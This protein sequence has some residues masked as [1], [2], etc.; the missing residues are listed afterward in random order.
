MLVDGAGRIWSMRPDAMMI[1]EATRQREAISESV[2]VVG[3]ERLEGSD[4]A[5]VRG[6]VAIVPVRG[7]LLRQQN[8]WFWSYE[9]ILRD[10]ALAQADRGV[11]AVV[12][13]ID[14]PGGMAAGCGDA[15]RELRNSGPKPIGAFVGGL[16]AS[17][18]FYLASAADRITV[19]SCATV[20]SLGTVIEFVDIEPMIERLGAR[21]I[22]VVAQQ[23]PNKRLDPESPEGHA[24]MQDLVDA[25]AA[26]FV[27]DV[28]EFRGRSE[29]EVL[30]R[31]GQGLVFDG[32]EALRRGMV[33]D[34]GTLSDLVAE[35]AGRDPI[36]SA[37]PAAAQPSEEAQMEWVDI[38]AAGLREQR[39]DLVEEISAAAIAEAN[40][41]RESEVERAVQTERARIAAIDEIAVAGHEDVVAAAKADGRSAADLALDIVK[42]EK[43]AGHSH[44]ASLREA[45]SSAAVKPAPKAP[46]GSVA[47]VTREEEWDADANLRAEFGDDKGAFLAWCKNSD[48]GRARILT[49]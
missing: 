7:L 32:N 13:D 19:G 2:D 49:R 18:A 43:A 12:L 17:A 48:A 31:F 5:H 10:V 47:A 41:G 11:E 42:A 36:T 27:A 40:S 25:G 34:R 8:F 21:M 30:S 23:S 45:D 22:R 39:A 3:A 35:M 26:E 6:G 14:S 24:E 16:C 46:T 20:G 28:G 29:A 9:E 15:A 33:D 37:V 38:T 44:V 1:G 4:F